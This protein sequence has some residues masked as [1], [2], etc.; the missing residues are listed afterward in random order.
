MRTRRDRNRCALFRST[1]T[2]RG[3]TPGHTHCCDQCQ[4]VVRCYF[5]R[6]STF[7]TD[8]YVTDVACLL[9]HCNYTLDPAPT[10]VQ[11][12]SCLTKSTTTACRTNIPYTEDAGRVTASSVGAFWEPQQTVV[13]R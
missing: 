11:Q 5:D 2:T 4:A 1:I 3:E 7:T 10:E 6:S 9:D 13:T 12:T 8:C